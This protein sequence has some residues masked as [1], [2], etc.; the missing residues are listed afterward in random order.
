[1]QQGVVVAPIPLLP[2]HGLAVGLLAQLLD[3]QLLEAIHTRVVQ[4]LRVRVPLLLCQRH[5]NKAG[6]VN[7]GHL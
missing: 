3:V 2:V 5:A 7:G 1:M 4:R 6:K